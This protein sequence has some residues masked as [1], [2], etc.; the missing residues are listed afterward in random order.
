MKT[1][2]GDSADLRAFA[3]DLV[4]A[5]KIQ[6]NR[7]FKDKSLENEYMEAELQGSKRWIKGLGLAICVAYLLFLIPDYA[8]LGL[9]GSF[10]MILFNRIAFSL[11]VVTFYLAFK[12]AQSYRRLIGLYTIYEVWMSLSFCSIYWLYGTPN[13]PIQTMGLFTIIVGIFIIPNKWTNKLAVTAFLC[14]LFFSL[15]IVVLKD[16]SFAELSASIVYVLLV[17]SINVLHTYNLDSYKRNLFLSNKRL[18]HQSNTDPLTGIY[19]R[20]NLDAFISELV[21]AYKRDGSPFTLMLFDIDDYKSINDRFGHAAGDRIIKDIIVLVGKEL[22]KADRFIRWGG[23]E[24][25]I[26]LP[27][28]DKQQAIPLAYRLREQIR[29]YTFFNIG[30]ITCSF[31][32]AEYEES[33]GS[34]SLLNKSDEFLYR[35]K[36]AGKDRV[37]G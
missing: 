21:A 31:G 7:T 11:S 19:N 10:S 33:D 23:D 6:W 35:A 9:S 18:K 16:Y 8:I 2:T 15:T 13:L 5:G 27:N 37:E 25:V 34:E 32:I 24:F 14:G 20:N 26:L 28:C 30:H 4:T 36:A 17:I 22:R 1:K 3:D 29:N 12:P